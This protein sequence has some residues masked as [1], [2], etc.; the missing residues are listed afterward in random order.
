M[1]STIESLGEREIILRAWNIFSKHPNE[2]MGNNDDVVSLKVNDKFIV[3]HTDVL[4]ESHDVLP[5]MTPYQIARKS[6][7]MN[8]SDLASKS[9]KPE[10]VLV[11]LGL[12]RTYKIRDLTM[13]FKGLE[14]ASREYGA[15]ILGGDTSEALELFI[16][17]FIYGV[18]DVEPPKRGGAKPGDIVAVTGLFGLTSIA[19]KILLERRRVNVTKRVLNRVLRSVYYPNA[20]LKEGLA[21]K[22]LVSSSMDVSDGLAFSLHTIAEMSNVGIKITNIPIH[23]LAKKISKDSGLDPINLVF[24]EGGEE[25]ELLVTIPPDKWSN[26]VSSVRN[27]GGNLI[28]IGRVIH[29]KN[30]IVEVGKKVFNIERRGWSHFKAWDL[31]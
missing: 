11:S 13:L 16:A 23:P 15:Y 21:L 28:E 8:V 20:R 2:L 29:E 1:G 4:V 12:P 19:F 18:T 17:I 6:I 27:V 30:V 22:G 3:L 26:A 31:I 10:G 14:R 25:Y 9:V 5:G 24:Y 7:V